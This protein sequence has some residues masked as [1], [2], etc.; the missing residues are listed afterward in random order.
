MSELG[1]WSAFLAAAVIIN[2]TPGPD[3]A[4]ILSRTIAQG[5][6]AGIASSLGV[7]TGA[8]VHV[9]LAALGVA[10]VLASVPG[11]LLAVQIVGACYLTWLGIGALRSRPGA[12]G[13]EAP[14]TPPAQ[15]TFARIYLQGVA[16]DILNPKVAIFFMAF[17]PQFV[18][19]D[20]GAPGVQMAGLGAV[21][22]LIALAVEIPLVL[23]AARASE[24]LR[25][26][27]RVAETLNRVLGGVLLLLAARLTWSA[28]RDATAD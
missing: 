1:Y 13:G 12:S 25:G 14:P 5:K 27:T 11:A 19:A 18:R 21:V 20:A 7:C 8:L 9:L 10:A 22:I 17:L 24:S 23:F 16:V 4:F 3:I 26:S 28:W 2:I 6:T 15:S